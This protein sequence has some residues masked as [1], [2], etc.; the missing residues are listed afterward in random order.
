LPPQQTEVEIEE[1]SIDEALAVLAAVFDVD[2]VVYRGM[3]LAGPRPGEASLRQRL[4]SS[5]DRDLAEIL[6]RPRDDGQSTNIPG[7]EYILDA[8]RV[9][10]RDGN[11]SER[12][13]MLT[14][15]ACWMAAPELSDIL[16]YVDAF[17]EGKMLVRVLDAEPTEEDPCSQHLGLTVPA[18]GLGKDDHALPVIFHGPSY[19]KFAL[20][21]QEAHGI[22][23][24]DEYTRRVIARAREMEDAFADDEALQ[25]TVTIEVDQEMMAAVARRLADEVGCPLEVEDTLRGARVTA[26]VQ[27]CSLRDFCLALGRVAGAAFI[28]TENEKGYAWDVP[29]GPLE[30][31]LA[32]LPLPL[33][34]LVQ[35]TTFERDQVR[36]EAVRA[37]W[38][39]LG[40]AMIESFRGKA[41]RVADIPPTAHLAVQQLAY[42]T[43]AA[44]FVQ[45]SQ[46]L[47]ERNGKVPLWLYESEEAGSFELAAPGGSEFVGG[48]AYLRLKWE[49]TGQR[50]L[51]E[52][53]PPSERNPSAGEEQEGTA[54]PGEEEE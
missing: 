18:S 53:I 16:R 22:I 2:C 24:L 51:R 37:F 14:R 48:L 44:Q 19:D 1:A 34:A 47:P 49:L 52:R 17:T 27:D 38:K 54:P 9:L 5:I 26:H 7:Y 3:I 20:M 32:A 15:A 10:Y 40:P 23:P 41:G 42:V 33:W 39:A 31:L 6:F 4:S 50:V 11:V 12:Q 25:K 46:N 13:E 45:W 8:V 28:A 35:M 43:F 21:L 29:R 36:Q 30:Q